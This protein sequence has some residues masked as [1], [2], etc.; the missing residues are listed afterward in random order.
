M[1]KI[2]LSALACVAFAFNGFASNEATKEKT[3]V[4]VALV[5]V[6]NHVISFEKADKPCSVRV[7]GKDAYGNDF[8]TL[9]KYRDTSS[10]GCDQN[11]KNKVSQ[12]EKLGATIE[13]TVVTW[14]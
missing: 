5:Q 6:L 2:I 9:Y 11:K 7:I 4:E 13:K 12:L 8:D 1:K 3:A 10:D 14:G